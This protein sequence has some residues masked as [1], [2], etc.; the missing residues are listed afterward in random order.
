MQLMEPCISFMASRDLMTDPQSPIIDFYPNHFDIDMEGK[1]YEWQG[2]TLLPFI[3]EARLKK[4][5]M[6]IE[7][8]LP[9]VFYNRN[10]RRKDLLYVQY[11]GAGSAG[12]L[13][14]TVAS[15]YE[16]EEDDDQVE[17]G[18]V[19]SEMLQ[20]AD[21]TNEGTSFA[22]NKTEEDEKATDATSLDVS[23][24]I[25][26]KVC[27][28]GAVCGYLVLPSRSRRLQPGKKVWF[29]PTANAYRAIYDY[30]PFI[31]G[32]VYTATYCLPDR[33]PGYVFKAVLLDGSEAGEAEEEA[34]GKVG[35]SKKKQRKANAAAMKKKQRKE[36]HGAVVG[37]SNSE[38]K[39]SHGH[40]ANR[41]RTHKEHGKGKGEG[42]SGGN[43]H[44]GSGKEEGKGEGFSRKRKRGGKKRNAVGG[45]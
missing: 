5:L 17:D 1:K 30:P 37:L 41:H 29:P 36:G 38:N 18:V 7:K 31:N 39:P 34:G 3:D 9:K 19:D 45:D 27:K 4:V 21:G 11:G 32:S 22:V 35:R 15:L 28:H 13:G 20:E 2:V 12:R 8:T 40:H 33:Q 42:S 25:T 10:Q 24:E 6:P 14:D 23:V 44:S 16:G 26:S 43:G